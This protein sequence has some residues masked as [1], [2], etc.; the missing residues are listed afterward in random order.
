MTTMT[1]MTDNPESTVVAFDANGLFVGHVEL[2]RAGYWLVDCSGYP[3]SIWPTQ[4]AAEMY[5]RERGAVTIRPEGAE[6]AKQEQPQELS[7]CGCPKCGRLHR[8]PRPPAE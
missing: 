8:K 1:T 2:T 3:W 6:C 5:L 4:A 7:T